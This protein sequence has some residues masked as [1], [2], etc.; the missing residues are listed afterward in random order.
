[1]LALILRPIRRRQA[2]KALSARSAAADE[3]RRAKVRGD[4]RRAHAAQV[5]LTAATT[6]LLRAEL[7]MGR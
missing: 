3:L 6:E 2:I 1:M 7:A 4:T 5:R